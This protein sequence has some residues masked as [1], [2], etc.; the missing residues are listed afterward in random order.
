M[1]VFVFYLVDKD[2]YSIRIEREEKE[3]RGNLNRDTQINI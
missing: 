1:S 2:K 3:T